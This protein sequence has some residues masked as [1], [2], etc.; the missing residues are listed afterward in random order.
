[1]S[2]IPSKIFVKSTDIFSTLSINLFIAKYK[3]LRLTFLHDVST[4]FVI[5]YNI[6]IY[7][8]MTKYN[9]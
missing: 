5:I 3:L 2:S 8:I 4:Y 1:M 7:N 9:Q 6:I